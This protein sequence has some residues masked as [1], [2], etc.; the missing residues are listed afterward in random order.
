MYARL[1]RLSS[2]ALACFQLAGMSTVKSVSIL[3]YVRSSC[4][5]STLVLTRAPASPALAQAS[6]A[7]A[8]AAPEGSRTHTTAKTDTN[9]RLL[10]KPASR[11]TRHLAT[12]VILPTVGARDVAALT[13]KFGSRR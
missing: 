1:S 11:R 6:S 13:R 9:A 2:K 8:R 3:V 12:P 10:N 5:N 4:R 7:A